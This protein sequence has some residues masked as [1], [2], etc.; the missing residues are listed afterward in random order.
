MGADV[1]AILCGAYLFGLLLMGIPG[2]VVGIPSG[3]IVSLGAGVAIAFL[4]RRIWR[5]H[6][7]P[8]LW[9]VAGL[10]GF[11]AGLYFHLRLPQ[12]GSTDLCHWVQS[13][14][15]ERSV[16]CSAVAT[17]Q[18]ASASVQ[19]S[20]RVA[21][22]PRLTRSQ[23]LQFDLVATQI[24][25]EASSPTPV[26]GKV[27]V[28]LPPV[29]G[30][31][32]YPGLTITVT[33]SLYRPKP[34]ANP[35]SFDFEQYL[36]QQDIFTGLNG[37]RVEYPTGP[38]PSP[39]LLWSIR[40]RIVQVQERGLGKSTGALVSAMVLGKGAVAVPDLIQT[41][42]KRTGLAHALAA[43]GTQVS[44]LIGVILACTQRLP[45]S[46]RAS[47]GLGLIAIY[48]G[49]TGLEPSVLRAGIMGGFVLLA[50][51]FDRKL[52][53]LGCL[54]LAATLLLLYNPAWIFDIGFQ[55][56][57]LATL[58]LLVTVPSLT[59]WF[60]WLPST[61]S[62]LVAVPI[63]AYLWTLPLQTFWFGVVSPYTIP[64]NILAGLLITIISIGGM[65]SAAA[66]LLSPPLGIV[67]A[68]VLSYPAE[69]LLKLAEVGSQLPGNRWALGNIAVWQVLLVYSLMVII[70]RCPKLHRYW[71]IGLTVALAAVLIPVGYQTAN[72]SQV[73]VLATAERPV[74]VVQDRG[75]AGLIHSGSSKDIDFTVLPFLQQQGINQLDW[76]IAPSLRPTDIDA[77]THLLT[78]TPINLFYSSPADP[79]ATLV[80]QSKPPNPSD[81]SYQNL[82]HQIKTQRGIALPLALSRP[83]K[84]GATAIE[85]R[86]AKPD[87]LTLQV[88]DQT[89]LWLNGVP[90]LQRQVDLSQ[91]VGKAQVI[92][93]SGKALSPELLNRLQPQVAI[94]YG[95]SMDATTEQ[96]MQQHQVK[97]HLLRETGA[98]QW[99]AQQ[100]FT[101][102]DSR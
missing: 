3:A 63:A 49:L 9:L 50:M 12:P 55:L 37:D 60:D 99:N 1:A 14:R 45:Q 13:D 29:A 91:R 27:Y 39:P 102:M 72:L 81:S 57:F 84:L 64:V 18:S 33:G 70:W 74:L 17:A 2:T 82:L 68:W 100:G 16:A 48:I 77:W 76:A 22:A 93:W 75:R 69:W 80:V 51:A 79:P 6:L 47:L 5:S 67:T 53:P 90:A 7:P 83:L 65:V 4:Q 11:G 25:P 54:L 61:L 71:W 42:F 8:A 78:Q 98:L 101:G 58:G 41:Q 31:Q 97:V 66:A 88:Q 73:T 62:P 24:E 20:G 40:Q 43:S 10:V 32:L 95:P 44:L 36:Q 86:F 52:K 38:K 59:A 85:Y 21:S 15:I 92:G 94:L 56:S 35:G 28:T 46:L 96:W 19:I 23:R 26:S 87:I 34:A 30:E 89:W